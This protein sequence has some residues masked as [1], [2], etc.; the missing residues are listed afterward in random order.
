MVLLVKQ[1]SP[2]SSAGTALKID[3][4]LSPVLSHFQHLLDKINEY[5]GKAATR[6]SI[7]LLL[8]HVV[9]RQPSWKHK[10]SQAPLLPSLLKCLKVRGVWEPGGNG[11]RVTRGMRAEANFQRSGTGRV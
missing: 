4:R 11:A 2:V 1:D 5:V 8:G 7:L 6:L 3:V 10:L 9:R